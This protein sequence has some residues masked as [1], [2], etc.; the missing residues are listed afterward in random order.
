MTDNRQTF[1]FTVAPEQSGERL[2]R[3]LAGQSE[4]LSRTRIQALISMYVSGD[5]RLMRKAIRDYGNSR[6]SDGLTQSRYP[7]RDMQ[8]IPTFSLFW[9]SMVHDYWMYRA[10]DPFVQSFLDGID[11]VIRWH[12]ARMNV[13]TMMNGPLEWWNFVDWSWP[14]SDTERSG[15]VP[16]GTRNG[17]SSILSLQ[18]AY[19]L[20]QAAELFEHFGRSDRAAFCWERADFIRLKTRALCWDNTRQLLADT[21]EKKAFSQH[22]NIWAVLTDAVPQEAQAALLHRIMVDTSIR[23]ATYYFKFYLFEALKKT[24]QGD[25]FLPQ[26]APWHSMIGNGLSTFAESPEPVRS[27]CH[28]WSASPVYQLLS[29]VCGINPG[30]PGFE[31]VRIAPFLGA[32]EFAEGKMPHPKGDISVR[33]QKTAGGGLSGEVELPEGLTGT[34]HWKGNEQPLKGGKQQ[35]AF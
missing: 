18:Y 26:L 33:F 12:D 25:E 17:G 6:I 22:A 34:L 30:A 20:R 3:F 11:D 4:E 10:D 2:D 28:A 31:T 21:P 24:G 29:T 9:V 5:D 13:E 1:T 23:Q 15:G 7:C 32:L 14:C 19:T 16:D 35:V 8:I 27:D